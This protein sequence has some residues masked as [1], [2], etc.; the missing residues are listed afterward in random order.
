MFYMA[1]NET[2]RPPL[3]KETAMNIKTEIVALAVRVLAEKKIISK[4]DNFTEFLTVIMTGE[5]FDRRLASTV[6]T[7]SDKAVAAVKSYKINRELNKPL[8]RVSSVR[9]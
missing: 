6:V 4:P 5:T 7:S 2:P 3:P 8:R 9:V 1:Y